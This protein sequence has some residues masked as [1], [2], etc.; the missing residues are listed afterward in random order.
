MEAP[1]IC[2][3]CWQGVGRL[4]R[5]SLP[6]GCEHW[7]CDSCAAV[8]EKCLHPAC[9]KTRA[10]LADTRVLATG[11]T[12]VRHAACGHPDHP[13]SAVCPH[14]VWTHIN[15][16]IKIG[17]VP[18]ALSSL[19]LTAPRQQLLALYPDLPRHNTW[20][21][22]I[23]VWPAL[24]DTVDT[25][26]WVDKTDV[27]VIWSNRNCVLTA[28]S[29]TESIKLSLARGM[30]LFPLGKMALET[31]DLV[32]PGP[33]KPLPGE[34][35][36]CQRMG[37]VI[38]NNN[39]S[40]LQCSPYEYVTAP[41]FNNLLCRPI[42]P[43]PGIMVQVGTVDHGLYTFYVIP[44][45]EGRRYQCWLCGRVHD[46]PQALYTNCVPRRLIGIRVGPNITDAPIVLFDAA[47]KANVPGLADF[48]PSTQSYPD[49]SR[50]SAQWSQTLYQHCRV[51]RVEQP[52]TDTAALAYQCLNLLSAAVVVIV[53]RTKQHVHIVAQMY[54]AALKHAEP[55]LPSFIPQPVGSCNE[56]CRLGPITLLESHAAHLSI[57][58]CVLTLVLCG[59][60]MCTTAF[61]NTLETPKQT[62][63]YAFWDTSNTILP[64]GHRTIY[65]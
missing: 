36:I 61:T 1:L 54:P 15:P 53:W 55:T 23:T 2:E 9:L 50:I 28:T 3:Y 58:A 64:M 57:V 16:D 11:H 21:V 48:T 65:G 43:T 38:K 60:D 10:G 39:M 56:E 46:T 13:Q 35:T 63:A 26:V 45:P 47:L 32:R 34:R 19:T 7:A 4:S 52:V 30:R 8:S 42:N 18:P 62:V 41:A 40:L 44:T 27:V 59:D 17:P 20:P 33:A 51:W 29:G 49:F 24:I 14:S 6:S 22:N 25:G 37:N 5:R 31:V 12:F